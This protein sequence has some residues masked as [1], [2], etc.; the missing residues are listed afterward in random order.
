MQFS[1]SALQRDIAIFSWKCFLLLLNVELIQTE[2]QNEEKITVYFAEI[3]K[4]E[5][6]L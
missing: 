3:Y 5:L 4:V 6:E 2:K 1:K